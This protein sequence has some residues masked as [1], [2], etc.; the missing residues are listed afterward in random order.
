M[1][2]TYGYA[3]EFSS[4]EDVDQQAQQRLNDQADPFNQL[5]PSK[6]EINEILETIR[7]VSPDKNVDFPDDTLA[8]LLDHFKIQRGPIVDSTRS[9]YKKIALR[10]IRGNLHSDATNGTSE[11][12]NNSGY[13]VDDNNKQ[14]V[15]VHSSDEDEPMPP[16]SSQ[17][18]VDMVN[19]AINPE[20]ME[21]DLDLNKSNQIREIKPIEISSS[22]DSE[23]DDETEESDNETTVLSKKI[24]STAL[25]TD[26][27]QP[28]ASTPI[29]KNLKTKQTPKIRAKSSVKP[30]ISEVEEKKHFTRS[31]RSGSASQKS[32]LSSS[33][34]SAG[35]SLLVSEASAPKLDTSSRLATK[36]TSKF[37]FKILIS[38]ILMVALA[39]FLYLYKAEILK[40]KD[41][42]LSIKFN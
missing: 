33:D 7:N 18:S 38:A 31:R 4:D 25:A 14:G 42:V 6:E 26:V 35:T 37:S 2:T 29:S 5:K 10:A 8:A 16:V 40:H 15:D 11:P 1:A 19:G 39:L 23:A 3:G 34:T 30:V 12:N 32:N 22:S 36:Q 41:R 17:E 21:V 24:D 9:L 28:I 13:D 20:P 27:P